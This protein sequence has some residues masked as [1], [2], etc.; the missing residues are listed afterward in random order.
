MD[1]SL[2]RD[3]AVS[4]NDAPGGCSAAAPLLEGPSTS[5]PVGGAFG[6]A[7]SASPTSV[8]V[9]LHRQVVHD[10]PWPLVFHF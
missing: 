6:S 3:L 7:V 1:N 10:S 2:I 5:V 8:R 4:S 9:H